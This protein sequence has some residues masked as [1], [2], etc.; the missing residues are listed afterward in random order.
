MVRRPRVV[1]EGGL[2]HVYNRIASGEPV[3]ADPEESIDFIDTIREIKQRDGWKVLAWCV[4]SNHY[5]LVI[6][7]SSVPLWRGMHA[8]QNRFSRRY[9]RRFRRTGALWQ[10]R[11]KAKYIDDQAYLDRLIVYVHV[12]PVKAGVVEDA[13]AYPFGGHREVKKRVR[14]PLVNV[15]ELLLCFGTTEKVARRNYLS[16]MRVESDPGSAEHRFSWHPF[17][18]SRD[19]ELEV[20]GEAASVDFL[21]RST[22]LERP[23]VEA[24]EFLG[25]AC[26][27]AGLNLERLSSRSRDRATAAARRLVVTLGVERWGQRGTDLARVLRKNGDV[28]SAWVGEGVRK[29]LDDVEFARDMDRLDGEL[30]RLLTSEDLDAIGRG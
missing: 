9:N 2:Y 18:A 11:Y 30:S 4:M 6:R 25:L 19:A 7:T 14:S 20:N 5:H 15:E 10:S 8:I 16:A 1:V 29:R 12:N 21:G 24:A 27:V 26:K 17:K 13:A 3:F 22:G 23:Q 28:V